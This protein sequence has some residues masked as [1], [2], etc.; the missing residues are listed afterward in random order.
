MEKEEERLDKY[1]DR[2]NY[3]VVV[4][5]WYWRNFV[6]V[7]EICERRRRAIQMDRGTISKSMFV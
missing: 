7:M 2:L 3:L 1:L 4:F 6:H 5:L